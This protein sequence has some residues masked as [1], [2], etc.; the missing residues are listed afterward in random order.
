MRSATV[1]SKR[2]EPI[3]NSYSLYKLALGIASGM[4][5]LSTQ[6]IIHR[7]L[8]ARNILLG[9]S[10][11]PKISDFGMSRKLDGGDVYQ[12]SAS[13]NVMG[14]LLW[15][16]PEA[17]ENN[18]S[19]A[20]DVW[21]YG[22]VLI[23]MMTGKSPYCSQSFSNVLDLASRVRDKALSPIHDLDWLKKFYEVSAPS[24]LRELAE[25]CFQQRPDKRPS[26]QQICSFL[27]KSNPDYYKN[28]QNE[29]DNAELA[30]QNLNATAAAASSSGS[31]GDYAQEDAASK[32]ELQADNVDL[33]SLQLLSELGSGAYGKVFLGQLAGGRFCAVKQWKRGASAEGSLHREFEMMASVPKHKNLVRTYGLLTEGDTL[34]IVMEFVP[35]GSL[36]NFVTRYRKRTPLRLPWLVLLPPRTAFFLTGS[37]SEFGNLSNLLIWKICVGMASG[38]R[39]LA[40]VGLVHRDFSARNILLDSETEPKVS[41]FGFSR[42]LK[43][44]QSQAQTQ[45]GA[46]RLLP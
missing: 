37:V 40:K 22:C 34:S 27:E 7:D 18:F 10:M 29:L 4:A 16:A 13:G 36:E 12:T 38:M 5:H 15:T 23:E 8:A 24:W 21:A 1:N 9:L 35:C 14:P 11:I 28:Y 43:A 20:S 32:L 41:D 39:E 26:F 46:L 2:G 6:G 44:D 31:G 3:F 45:T 33:T 19:Q 25:S 30:R 17:L 42:A